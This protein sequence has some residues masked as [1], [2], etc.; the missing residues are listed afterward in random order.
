V[1][2]A[3]ADPAAAPAAAAPAA[4][5]AAAP[6]RAALKSPLAGPSEE[7]LRQEALSDPT[8]KALFEIFPVE[9]TKVEEM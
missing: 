2:I 6:P 7:E 1:H 5:P 9:R 4:L 3:L 8:V